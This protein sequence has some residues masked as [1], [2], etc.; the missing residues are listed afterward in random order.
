MLAK[1]ALKSLI[2]S[3]CE[4]KIDQGLFVCFTLSLELLRLNVYFFL[5]L[6]DR[7]KWKRRKEKNRQLC[8]VA[9]MLTSKRFAFMFKP[10]PVKSKTERKQSHTD[11]QTISAYNTALE[12]RKEAPGC[13][14]GGVEKRKQRLILAF[15]PNSLSCP[16]VA[17]AIPGSLLPR[18]AD[19]SCECFD[20]TVIRN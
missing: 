15:R 9:A 12:T 5:K 10:L 14:P 2:I 18:V 8:F 17:R 16:A 20:K 13:S 4:N 1:L 11:T 7:P 6:C 3:C 19:S